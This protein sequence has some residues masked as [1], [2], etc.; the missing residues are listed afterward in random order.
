MW[1]SGGGVLWRCIAQVHLAFSLCKFGN[2][3][4]LD[5]EDCNGRMILYRRQLVVL[6]CADL[7]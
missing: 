7:M 2:R 6:Q 3:L 1:D 5:R 4:V